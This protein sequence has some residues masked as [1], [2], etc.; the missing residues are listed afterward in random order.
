[1]EPLDQSSQVALTELDSRNRP[2]RCWGKISQDH[3]RVVGVGPSGGRGGAG[4]A[5]R[6]WGSNGRRVLLWGADDTFDSTVDWANGT[7]SGR[8]LRFQDGTA[9][10]LRVV[11]GGAAK[12]ASRPWSAGRPRRRGPAPQPSPSQPR[13]GSRPARWRPPASGQLERWRGSLRRHGLRTIS[14]T[15]GLDRRQDLDRLLETRASQASAR[16][17]PATMWV[18][19]QWLVGSP[20]A[21]ASLYILVEHQETSVAAQKERQWLSM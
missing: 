3:L 4:C 20:T 14:E 2:R 12:A 6:R 19:G 10:V 11:G 18:A 15:V 13:T 7:I 5:R 9:L 16:Y 1:M 21:M 8:D 17:L